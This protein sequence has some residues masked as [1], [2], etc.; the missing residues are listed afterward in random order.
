MSIH[1]AQGEL[2]VLE[3][4]LGLEEELKSAGKRKL[5]NEVA[6]NERQRVAQES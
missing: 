4:I 2:D 1:Q 5:A 3:R 6:E